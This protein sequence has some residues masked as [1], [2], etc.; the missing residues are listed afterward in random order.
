MP[1]QIFTLNVFYN[2]GIPAPIFMHDLPLHFTTVIDSL[3][4][5]Y[6]SFSKSK[7]KSSNLRAKL[8]KQWGPRRA[9][10][11]YISS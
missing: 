4:V 10:W 2:T 9:R 8:A 1:P 5:C 6:N 7:Q 3:I 11:A